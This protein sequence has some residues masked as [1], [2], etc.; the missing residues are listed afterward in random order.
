MT[1]INHKIV[2]HPFWQMYNGMRDTIAYAKN[3]G[4]L[5]HEQK[6]IDGITEAVETYDIA[7]PSFKQQW[8]RLNERK[9]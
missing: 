3:K 1:K 7:D 6:Y 5:P 9:D 8:E 4:L 2:S